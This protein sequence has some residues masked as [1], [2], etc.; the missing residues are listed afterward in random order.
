MTGGA[1]VIVNPASGRGRG[2]RAL[3]D[4]R[5]TFAA[6]GV[7]DVRVT[8]AKGDERRVARCAI[9]DGCSTL[10]AVGGDGTWSNVANAI[11][12][13]GADCRLG[14]LAMGT[15][16]DF[17]KTVGAPARD[18]QATAQLAVGGG[19]VRVDVGRIEDRYFLNVA[20]FGFDIA[21]LEDI[22]RISWLRG[23]ALYMYSA[24][25]Q[26]FGYPGIEIDI[27]SERQARGTAPHLMLIVANARNFGGAFRI[28]PEA[29]LT[30][31][32]LDAIAIGNA[33]PMRRLSLFGAATRGTH[34][35]HP[36]VTTEQ[37]PSFRL[38]FSAPPAY[39]TDGEYRRA[40][41][42]ELEIRCVPAALRVI[43]P[44]PELPT[45]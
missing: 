45:A 3:P 39:E 18:L 11:L 12:E 41:T 44:G 25:R 34:T 17:A 35:R 37:A 14:L 8:A 24:L 43:T 23:D 5:R 9:D 15:G 2:A 32:R 22:E 4:I 26:L 21:V 1:C 10:I 38:R 19:D 27:Q 7:T 13:S 33:R 30:D 16:N 31:G 6:V 29:S 36:E 20:G 28:A 42:D 40:Q